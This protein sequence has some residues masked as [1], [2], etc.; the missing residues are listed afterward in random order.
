VGHRIVSP[1]LLASWLLSF[2][3]QNGLVVLSAT[4]Q[5]SLEPQSDKET[6]QLCVI[7]GQLL[8]PLRFEPERVANANSSRAI[9]RKFSE[10][11]K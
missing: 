8:G 7:F 4:T 3:V 11:R 2:Q 6:K 1:A 10:K 5:R 9:H